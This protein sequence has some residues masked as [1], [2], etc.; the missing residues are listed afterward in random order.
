MR[1]NLK[2]IEGFRGTFVG[3]FKRMGTKSN[4]HGFSEP[5]ILLVNITD[6]KKRLISEHLWFN[7]TKG[8]QKIALIEGCKVRF[9][10]RV[11]PYIKGYINNRD[12]VDN[13][14][15]DYKLSHPTKIEVVIQ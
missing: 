15:L 9:D 2:E 3:E 6:S 13:R 11:K 4:Y 5:T 8:F 7:F 10:A 12:Y 14:E 1:K